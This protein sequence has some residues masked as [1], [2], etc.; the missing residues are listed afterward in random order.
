MKITK[1]ELEQ[2]IAEEIDRMITEEP[3]VFSE[4]D[5]GKMAGAAG[6]AGKRLT[7]K[8][9]SLSVFDAFKK[10]LGNLP[11]TKKADALV[12]LITQTVPEPEEL[13]KILSV[14]KTKLGAAAKQT[15]EFAGAG[16]PGSAKNVDWE[17]EAK[18]VAATTPPGPVQREP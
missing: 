13:A 4:L 17:G 11:G 7:Q 6:A 2:V 12:S 14:L 9:G 10:K 3:E 16:L 15:A 1:S 18:K 5:L 8:L